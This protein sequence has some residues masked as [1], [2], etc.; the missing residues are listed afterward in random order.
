MEGKE[1]REGKRG[2]RGGQEDEEKDG[3][4]KEATDLVAGEEV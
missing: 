1:E 3:D 2:E 4:R